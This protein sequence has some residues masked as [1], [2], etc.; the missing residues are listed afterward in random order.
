MKHLKGGVDALPA[1]TFVVPTLNAGSLLPD[2]LKSIRGQDYPAERVEVLI[3]DGGSTDG[4]IDLAKEFGCR[5]IPNPRKL[6]G[7]GVA[8]GMDKASHGIKI[9]FA[10]DNRLPSRDWLRNMVRPFMEDGK[11]YATFGHFFVERRDPALNR[12]FS[13]VESSPFHLYVCGNESSKKL[14]EISYDVVEESDGYKVLGMTSEKFP[15][16][17]LA[18]GFALNTTALRSDKDGRKL[19]EL[20]S[21]SLD[22]DLDDILPV[23]KLIEHGYKLAYVPSA[24]IHHY[25]LATYRQ[26]TEKYLWKIRNNLVGGKAYTNARM[27]L[28]RRRQIREK[29]WFIYSISFAWPLQDAARGLRRDGDLAWLLH[30]MLCMFL[31]I[32]GFI[33]ALLNPKLALK[34]ALRISRTTQF[35]RRVGK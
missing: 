33:S 14:Y 32:L 6:C 35:T 1:V 23:I 11:I 8:V 16:L 13:L 17:G 24:P 30:P 27:F 5:V 3:V 12:Y 28:S 34:Y 9:F 22:E 31:A 18:N 19:L 15:I 26:F 10:A 21:R 20:L 25:H 29:L 7:P 4:T 2:C